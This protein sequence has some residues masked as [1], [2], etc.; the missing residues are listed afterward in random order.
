MIGVLDVPIPV[1]QINTEPTG[2]L[3]SNFFGYS[4]GYFVED[5]LKPGYGYWI[6]S[7]ADGII[8]LNSPLVKERSIV[9]LNSDWASITITDARSREVKLYLSEDA[10][11]AMFT[12]PPMPPEG[13]FDIRFST[14]LLVESISGESKIFSIA[15][16]EYPIRINVEGVNLNVSD[17]IDEKLLNETIRDGGELIISDSKVNKIIINGNYTNEFPVSF[18]LE[19]NYPNPFNPNTTIRFS[20]PKEVDVNLSVFNILGEKVRELKNE[21]MKPGYYEVEFDA[22]SLASGIYLYRINAGEYL[23]TKKMILLK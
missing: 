4:S 13:A 21:M 23:E 3:I 16:A 12:L 6:K 18:N 20:I 22:S 10:D 8:L 19:Q 9:K 2:I 15:G 17:L 5:T 7:S 1:L 14:G 11:K